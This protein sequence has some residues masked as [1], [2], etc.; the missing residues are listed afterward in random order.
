MK[1]HVPILSEVYNHLDQDFSQRS[2]THQQSITPVQNASVFHVTTP[3]IIPVSVDAAFTPKT[4]MLICS[5]CGYNGHT[6]D[7]CYIIH[8][9]PVGFKH[10]TQPSSTSTPN[11][12]VVAQLALTVPEDN[13]NTD[14]LQNINTLT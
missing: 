1:K 5:D 13:K 12:P 4:N 6:I 8:G 3:D 10:K 14:Q 11:K 9:Y 2:I 7:K